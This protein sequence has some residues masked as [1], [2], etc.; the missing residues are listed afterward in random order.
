MYSGEF[1]CM[2]EASSSQ[3]CCMRYTSLWIGIEFLMLPRCFDILLILF[4]KVAVWLVVHAIHVSN[5]VADVQNSIK[6]HGK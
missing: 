5:G 6:D 1:I 4:Q 3:K 2:C